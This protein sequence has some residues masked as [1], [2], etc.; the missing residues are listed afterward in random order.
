M[1]LSV[2]LC[3]CCCCFGDEW[4][5]KRA[6]AAFAMAQ[7]AEQQN[8]K[9]NKPI[10]DECQDCYGSGFRGDGRT[11]IKCPTCDG[12]GK[13][14]TGDAGPDVVSGDSAG[15]PETESLDPETAAA[16]EDPDLAG[17]EFT[18]DW[19]KK[20]KEME[21]IVAEAAVIYEK[22][23]IETPTGKDA[24]QKFGIKGIPVYMITDRTLNTVLDRI[25][26]TT[27]LVNLRASETKARAL[28]RA[29]KEFNE[30]NLKGAT[31]RI[32]V[33][34]TTKEKRG[35]GCVIRS[36]KTVTH[37]LT[38]NHVTLT[39]GLLFVE[40]SN[41]IESGQLAQSIV[42]GYQGRVIGRDAENDLAIIEIKC[43]QLP[44]LQDVGELRTFGCVAT[45]SAFPLGGEFVQV[46]VEVIEPKRVDNELIVEDGGIEV[47]ATRGEC[48]QGVSGAPLTIEG[49][50][51]GVSFGTVRGDADPFTVHAT[52][53]AIRKLIRETLDE[54]RN[55]AQSSGSSQPIDNQTIRK[56][57]A[58]TYWDESQIQF[59]VKPRSRARQHL[60]AEH[61][62]Q[63]SQL[64]GLSIWELVCLHDAI[65][66]GVI[67][68]E[69][70]RQI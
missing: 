20:C 17:L 42:G 18:A 51:V 57:I 62:F 23:D 45:S 46:D 7:T 5:L 44:F 64:N 34:G 33:Q 70:N 59:D 48:A 50:I 15:A 69:Q 52:G 21:P 36:S 37:V 40:P 30:R 58:A 41:A 19:C 1:L 11:K 3:V 24:V 10:S 14:K 60:I 56:M 12:T 13:R 25:D 2:A 55:S 66:K 49:T 65:H 29:R 35:T 16:D 31:V 22:I 8:A 61:G 26:G 43:P 6:K 47:V 4:S 27:T 28:K 67:T 9:P 53:P 32:R 39:D 68:Y 63:S 38:C 54:R